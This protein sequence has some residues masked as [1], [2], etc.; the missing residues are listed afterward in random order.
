[1]SDDAGL[2]EGLHESVVTRALLERLAQRAELTP[3]FEP[4]DPADQADVLA[5]HVGRAVLRSLHAPGAADEAARLATVREVLDLLRATDE[6]PE[7]GVRRL[8]A[9]TRPARPGRPPTYPDGVRPST[10]LADVALLTNAYGD[11]SL[12][13]EIQAELDTCD[14]V[15]LLC[16]F[17]KWHGM[18]TLAAPLVRLRERG[19]P[20]RVLTTTYLGSTD[21]KALDH[22]V[23]DYGAQVRVQYDPRSTR[24]HAKG[25]LFRRNTGFDT[26]YVGSSNLTV[27]ALLDGAVLDDA[28]FDDAVFDDAVRCRGGLP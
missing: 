1:M 2:S 3:T 21:Q 19:V 13:S 22:L 14:G 23:R 9:L 10:P 6:I 20:F 17:V 25:W 8:L 4:V 7:D 16:A 15:D 12:G 18:R 26:A 11:P 27:S 5:R 28:V 24:L